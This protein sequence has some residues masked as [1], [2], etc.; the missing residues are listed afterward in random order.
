MLQHND[1]KEQPPPPDGG[2]QPQPCALQKREKIR[3]QIQVVEV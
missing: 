1:E 2:R 3:V